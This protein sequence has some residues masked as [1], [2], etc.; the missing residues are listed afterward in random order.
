MAKKYKIKKADG[1]RHAI[2]C[3]KW[4]TPMKPRIS[5]TITFSDG[6]HRKKSDRSKDKVMLR[7]EVLA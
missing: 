2:P 5:G 7:K 6:V 1:I 3:T 4:E